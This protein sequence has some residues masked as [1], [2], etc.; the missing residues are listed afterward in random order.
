M[1]GAI[2]LDRDGVINRKP[3]AGAYV[4]AWNEFTFLPG[5]ICGLREL[6]TR[7]NRPLYVVTNQRGI[8]RGIVSREI[9]DEIH[10]LMTAE[11]AHAGV[12][13]AGIK[14][15]PHEIGACV[16]R[17]P[18]IGLFQAILAEDPTLDLGS[19]TIVG[20]ALSDV[21]A[22]HRLGVDALVVGDQ[23]A[24][25]AAESRARG[26]AVRDTAG[27]LAELVASGALDDQPAGTALAHTAS[28]AKSG[29]AAT[30]VGEPAVTSAEPDP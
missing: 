6:T 17:K 28:G 2:F 24:A 4:T 22:A 10:A 13:L 29:M 15:C 30:S 3:P 1:S 19:S 11:L 12:T 23:A 5:A 18:L 27:S 26:M 8:A 16:C 21:E 14:L 20:D 9:V 7:S 25:V